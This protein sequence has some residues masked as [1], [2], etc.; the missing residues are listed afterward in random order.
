MDMINVGDRVRSYDFEGVDDCWVE[1]VVREI[2][3]RDRF[4][5]CSR[6]KIEVERSTSE[7]DKG[8]FSQG[9][10]FFVYPPVNGTPTSMG[11]VC[12]FV[13]KLED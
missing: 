9:P 3:K 11:R 2:G 10:G 8:I 4:D 12:N 1:G 7:G 13:K 6:Y 5:S